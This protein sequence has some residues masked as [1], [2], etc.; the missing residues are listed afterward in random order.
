MPIIGLIIIL[1][2]FIGGGYWLVWEDRRYH[3]RLG[4]TASEAP[5]PADRSAQDIL[6]ELRATLAVRE[7][8]IRDLREKGGRLVVDRDRWEAAARRLE[9]EIASLR[10]GAEAAGRPLGS[11]W[12]KFRELKAALRTCSTLMS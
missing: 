8:T 10:D 7:E 1:V 6:A 2:C 11:D 5:K 12:N 9:R 3:A 4:G